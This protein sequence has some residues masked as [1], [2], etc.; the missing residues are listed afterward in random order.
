MKFKIKLSSEFSRCKN[1]VSVNSIFIS[2]TVLLKVFEVVT[3]QNAFSGLG[4]STPIHLGW[5]RWNPDHHCFGFG[6]LPHLPHLFHL[7][8]LLLRIKQ[9]SVLKVILKNVV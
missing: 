1:T 8:A 6:H 3:F 2:Q 9:K 5:N 4:F 7:R